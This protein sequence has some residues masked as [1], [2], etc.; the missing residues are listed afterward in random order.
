MFFIFGFGPR[1]KDL[2][3]DKYRTCENCGNH[4]QW[5]HSET[6]NWLTLFFIPV[7]PFGRKRSL[8]CPICSWGWEEKSAPDD[9]N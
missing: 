3:P 5:R 9:K 6:S 2:G 4:Q 7:I 1:V 8:H